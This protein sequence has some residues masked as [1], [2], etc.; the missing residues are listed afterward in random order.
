MLFHTYSSMQAHRRAHDSAY[1]EI[2]HCRMDAAAPLAEIVATD[3]LRHW[4]KDSLYVHFDELDTFFS[5]YGAIFGSG[6]YNNLQSEPIDPYGVNYF[7][8][9]RVRE[10]VA[11]LQASDAPERD[12]LAAW[13]Q[14]A[15]GV[16]VLGI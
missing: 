14:D 16:Y 3:S 13:L 10:I 9:D 15:R 5:A 1:M 4:Q 6:V 12:V 7:S 11:R 8:P 2:Q